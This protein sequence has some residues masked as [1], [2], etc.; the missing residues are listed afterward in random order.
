MDREAAERALVK[1]A[2]QSAFGTSPLATWRHLRGE[3]FRG[4]TTIETANTLYRFIDGV[5]AARARRPLPGQVA[6][7]ESPPAMRGVELIGF[8]SNEGGLWSLSPRWRDGAWAVLTTPHAS[9]TLTSPT[10]SCT[11]ARPPSTKNVLT[12]PPTQ[13]PTVRRPAPPSMTK[14]QTAPIVVGS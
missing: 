10:L 5:F 12:A 6:P 9:F 11:I 8:L 13:P 14:L 7:W 2:K 4:E 3:A 1:I